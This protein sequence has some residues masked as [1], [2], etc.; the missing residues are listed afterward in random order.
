MQLKQ[1]TY[2]CGVL[3]IWKSRSFQQSKVCSAKG[4]WLFRS[5][6]TRAQHCRQMQVVTG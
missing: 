3:V 6:G 1:N 5:G 2:Q 4:E